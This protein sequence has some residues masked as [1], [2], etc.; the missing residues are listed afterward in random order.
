MTNARLSL[1]RPAFSTRVPC[2]RPDQ[3]SQ[4][5]KPKTLALDAQDPAA[6][7]ILLGNAWHSLQSV[8][9]LEMYRRWNLAVS[10]TDGRLAEAVVLRF[11]SAR[12]ALRSGLQS[13]RKLKDG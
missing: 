4:P 10:F 13:Y 6:A 7:T 2:L 12:I 3:K 9:I 5:I 8:S 11:P 1:S